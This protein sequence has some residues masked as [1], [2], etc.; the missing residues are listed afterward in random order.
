ML[1]NNR[2]MLRQTLLQTQ[3]NTLI[4]S[5]VIAILTFYSEHKGLVSSNS[6]TTLPSEISVFTFPPFSSFFPFNFFFLS[7]T[8]FCKQLLQQKQLFNSCFIYWRHCMPGTKRGV[9]KTNSHLNIISSSRRVL[10]YLFSSCENCGTEIQGM[11]KTHISSERQ[12]RLKSFLPDIKKIS[13]TSL[14][15]KGNAIFILLFI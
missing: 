10:F 3:S 4:S 7:A 13:I 11:P 14:F 12:S 15:W 5:L 6:K 8:T 1:V 9:L 2:R